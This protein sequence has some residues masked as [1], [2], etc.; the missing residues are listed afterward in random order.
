MNLAMSIECF[1]L[2]GDYFPDI[3][4]T[5]NVLEFVFSALCAQIVSIVRA[6]NGIE[7]PTLI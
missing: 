1:F 5:V 6:V 4:A 7:G 2:F 3:C